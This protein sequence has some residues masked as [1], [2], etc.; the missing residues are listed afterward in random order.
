MVALTWQFSYSA[1]DA[2]ALRGL[3]HI[4]FH[5]KEEVII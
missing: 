1:V 5:E 3:Y 4:L 2:R